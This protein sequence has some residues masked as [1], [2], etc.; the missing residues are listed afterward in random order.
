MS[1]AESLTPGWWQAREVAVQD[2]GNKVFHHPTAGTLAL[3]WDT[4]SSSTVPQQRRHLDGAA[5]QSLEE[6]APDLTA[7]TAAPGAG[8]RPTRRR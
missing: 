1:L 2:T 8:S 5:R 4:L 6:G 7:A 3:D